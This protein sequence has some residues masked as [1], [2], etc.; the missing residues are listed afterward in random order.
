[1]KLH[2]KIFGIGLLTA[3]IVPHLY[4][5]GYSLLTAFERVSGQGQDACATSGQGQ[6]TC[7]T[8]AMMLISGYSGIGKSVME[9][10][11]LLRFVRSFPA[12]GLSC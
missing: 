4:E 6:D 12:P 8:S 5:K 7:A 2:Q 1:M 3:V 10:P 9:S 11:P